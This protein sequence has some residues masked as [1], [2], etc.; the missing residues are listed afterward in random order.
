MNIENKWILNKRKYHRLA[1]HLP[2]KPAQDIP[3]CSIF[4]F[5][6]IFTYTWFG[7]KCRHSTKT[8]TS[9]DEKWHFHHLLCNFHML[10]LFSI[11]YDRVK[12]N[13]SPIWLTFWIEFRPFNN[14][15]VM[16]WL[17]FFFGQTTPQAHVREAVFSKKFFQS[18]CE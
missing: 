5:F 12:Q 16:K 7:T 11:V 17:I 13:H 15:C 2:A 1:R 9:F 10:T 4:R 14:A 18:T 3:F 6:S 8:T